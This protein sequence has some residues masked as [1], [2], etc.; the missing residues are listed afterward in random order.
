MADERLHPLDPT[1]L[2]DTFPIVAGVVIIAGVN[3]V[4]Y[5]AGHSLFIC[6]LVG[7]L[8]T[9]PYLIVFLYQG[10]P[11]AFRTVDLPRGMLPLVLWL[12]LTPIPME[13]RGGIPEPAL[14]VCTVVSHA[15]LIALIFAFHRWRPLVSERVEFFAAL[16]LAGV[17]CYLSSN[18]S[19]LALTDSPLPNL[20][21]DVFYFLG[22]SINDLEDKCIPSTLP[23]ARAR[24]PSRIRER[25]A[26]TAF[27]VVMHPVVG[28]VVS[29]VLFVYFVYCFRNSE[30]FYR[31][32]DYPNRVRFSGDL[33]TSR[34]A[35]EPPPT[36]EP[37]L[38]V[39]IEGG[40]PSSSGEEY[41]EEENSDTEQV[42]SDDSDP[43]PELP[44]SS[45]LQAPSV[46]AGARRFPPRMAQSPQTGKQSRIRRI[47]SHT[48]SDHLTAGGT[49]KNVYP[50]R[51]N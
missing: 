15:A 34:S 46:I 21:R 39:L 14:T 49:T 35:L 13:L 4:I 1:S 12:L 37:P 20:I 22:F 2:L 3:Y 25:F 51:R 31:K 24:A 29:V 47:T 8:C 43:N 27:L 5:L 42:A 18:R 7:G 32:S 45:F 40:S 38:Q 30:G 19:A 28:G 44:H 10:L 48:G 16:V 6:S 9:L 23:Q 50:H 11:N 41:V 33:P 26:G 36:Y 17:L